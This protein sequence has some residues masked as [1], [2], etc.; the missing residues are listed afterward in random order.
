MTCKSEQ[1]GNNLIYLDN[2]LDYFDYVKST[3]CYEYR[4]F[5]RVINTYK[6]YINK[7]RVI[8][9][10]D[11]LKLFENDLDVFIADSIIVRII[12]QRDFEIDDD[13]NIIIYNPEDLTA[14]EKKELKQFAENCR[15]NVNFEKNNE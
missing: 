11:A 15:Y 5:S 6:Y 1:S 9:C 13:Y 8:L 2:L 3:G 12:P 7:Y 10:W 14:D 4:D